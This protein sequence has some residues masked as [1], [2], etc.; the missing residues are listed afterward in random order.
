MGFPYI[1][2][3]TDG[4]YALVHVWTVNVDDKFKE[5]F[6][7]SSKNPNVKDYSPKAVEELQAAMVK[8]FG[9]AAAKHKVKYCMQSQENYDPVY[10]GLGKDLLKMLKGNPGVREKMKI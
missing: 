4:T 7:I 8:L 10:V 3:R 2:K 1:S 9:P 5:R 6:E